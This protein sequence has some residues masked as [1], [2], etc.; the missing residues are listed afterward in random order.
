[1]RRILVTGMSGTGKST[2]LV[3]LARRGYRV[4]DTDDDDWSE[5]VSL[6]DG[7]GQE[8]VWREDLMSA[9]LAE[10]GEQALYVSGCTSNQSTFY[11]R[12][13][14]VVLLTAPTDVLLG[15]ILDRTTNRFGKH[16]AERDRILEDVATV[17]PLLRRTASVVISTAQP[18]DDVVDAVEAVARSGSPD[19]WLE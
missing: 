6:P 17:E 14:A 12:F 1:M 9:L 2:V 18:L 11:D 4:I 3:E 13:E 19:P 10:E 5:D 7:S 15:R 8:R 16:P